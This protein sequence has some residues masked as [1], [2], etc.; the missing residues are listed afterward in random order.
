MQYPLLGLLLIALTGCAAGM[1]KGSTCVVSEGYLDAETSFTWW[2]FSEIDVI[3][4]TSYVSPI[5]QSA[6]RDVVVAEL[7]RKGL[8]FVERGES[9]QWTDVEVALTLRVWREVVSV[10][11]N[12]LPCQGT[13]CWEHID[14]TSATGVEMQTMGFLAADVYHL[15]KPIWR[16]WVERSLYTPDRDTAGEVIAQAVPLLFKTFPP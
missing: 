4:S 12:E 11:N 9:A 2:D 5:M 14:L 10:T 13:R 7:A 15:G 8:E 6:L 3:D 16:G 1:N